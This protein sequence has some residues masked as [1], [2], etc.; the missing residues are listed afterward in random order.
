VLR[1]QHG[2]GDVARESEATL[3]QRPHEP[4]RRNALG[5]WQLPG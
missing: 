4:Q 3:L 2:Y 5:K 1:Q